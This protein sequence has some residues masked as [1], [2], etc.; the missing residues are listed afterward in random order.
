MQAIELRRRALGEQAKPAEE[1]SG[2]EEVKEE[3]SGAVKEEVVAVP[4]GADV[5]PAVPEAVDVV[6]VEDSVENSNIINR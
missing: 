3:K 5:V 6:L 1:E 4:E 2:A